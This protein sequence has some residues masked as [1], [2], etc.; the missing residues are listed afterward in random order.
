MIFVPFGLCKKGLWIVCFLLLM[1][2]FDRPS[3]EMPNSVVFG[4][5]DFTTTG[6][7]NQRSDIR[8]IISHSS[9]DNETLEYDISLL[10]LQQPI[11]YDNYVRPLC[12]ATIE[13]ETTVYQ[14]CYA[15]GWGALSMPPEGS[16]TGR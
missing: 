6:S 1:N 3:D 5:T 11:E 7:T 13:Q 9:Y 12:L 15:T 8:R 2:S 16:S 10:E 14:N 4:Q